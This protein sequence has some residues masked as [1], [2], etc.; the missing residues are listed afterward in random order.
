MK[1]NKAICYEV[2]SVSKPY[3]E[4]KHYVFFV[5]QFTDNDDKH[6]LV[7]RTDNEYKKGL[8][9]RFNQL[10]DPSKQFELL[11]DNSWQNALLV[12]WRKYVSVFGYNCEI[13]EK[14]TFVSHEQIDGG[15]CYQL[16]NGNLESVLW[17]SKESPSA[18]SPQN[19]TSGQNN[20]QATNPHN[21]KIVES[22]DPDELFKTHPAQS[23][24]KNIGMH[25]L[26]GFIV[27]LGITAVA[28]AFTV[29]NAATLGTAGVVVA[30]FGVAS[31]LAGCGLF[32]VTQDYL[33]SVTQDLGVLTASSGNGVAS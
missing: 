4:D 25:I 20:L 11:S 17:D 9:Y 14:L 23:I 1:S 15:F 10:G 29:L 27:A 7:I 3:E 8:E 13:T 28:L 18:T 19:S 30:T 26:S 31:I 5:V 21:I 24:V 12:A 22:L 16:E 2:C 32:K 33:S 6:I